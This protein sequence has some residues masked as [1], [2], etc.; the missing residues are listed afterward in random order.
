VTFDPWLIRHLHQLGDFYALSRFADVEQGLADHDMFSSARGVILEMIKANIAFPRG[1][2]ICEDPPVHS[3]HRGVLSRC[4][5]R[6]E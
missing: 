3:A 5:P 2:F 1:V 6:N 4:L